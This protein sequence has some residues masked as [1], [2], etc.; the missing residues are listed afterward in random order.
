LFGLTGA[1]LSRICGQLGFPA[2]RGKQIAQWIYRDQV[3]D[4]SEMTNLPRDTREKLAEVATIA[5]ST[6][7][8]RSQSEDGSV[9]FLLRLA[10][11]E[12]IESVLLPY[13]DRISV[14]VSSQV[15]CPMRCEFC[16]T[17][18]QGFVRNLSKAEILDQVLTASGEASRRISHVV[19]MGMGEPLL[20][21]DNVVDAARLISGELG[22]AMRRITISTVGLIP[23]IRRLAEL[24]LQLTLAVS[25]HTANQDMRNRLIPTASTYRI[26]ALIEACR[27]YADRTK[28]RITFEVILLKGL[29]DSPEDARALAKLLRGTMCHVNLIPF[30][31]IPDC[32]F[33]A[34]SG[35]V[36]RDFRTALESEGMEVTQRLARGAKSSAACGQLRGKI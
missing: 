11:G 36:V 34:P 30:N 17:G 6:I 28:R 31:E 7:V 3:S 25:L 5:R 10:D 29:N 15:G 27:E 16:A 14:C 23:Q 35:R 22:I 1:E 12:H 9:K 26:P 21:F 8:T 19:F 4:F 24:D 2:Y 32:E 20:N 13:E 33:R 18:Q